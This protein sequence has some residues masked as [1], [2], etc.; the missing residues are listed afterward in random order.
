M[1]FFDDKKREEIRKRQNTGFLT[2][3]LIRSEITDYYRLRIVINFILGLLIS[4]SLYHAGWKNL[5]FGDFDYTYALI[6]KWTII[7][8][9]TYAFTV[10]PTFRCA[11]FCV[12]I[13]AFGKQGQYPFTMLVMSNL[14]EGPITNMM[15]NYETTSEIVMCHIELQSKIVANRVALLTGPL[16]VLIEKLMG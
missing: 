7:S 1:G 6:V 3:Y 14:Q 12:L 8:F 15:T 10:S 13:G 5:N 16:E 9:S 2:D 11:L 4:S